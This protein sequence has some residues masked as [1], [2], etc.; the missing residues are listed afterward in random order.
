[1]KI[2]LSDQ[3]QMSRFTL[4]S[5]RLV[6]NPIENRGRPRKFRSDVCKQASVIDPLEQGKVIFGFAENASLRKQ[7]PALRASVIQGANLGFEES[8][9]VSERSPDSRQMVARY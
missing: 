9:K 6:H 7:S 3:P 2:R 4:T 1:M 8:I 5:D